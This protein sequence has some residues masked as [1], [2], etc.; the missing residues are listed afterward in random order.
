MFSERLLASYT[1]TASLQAFMLSQVAC[2]I[3]DGKFKIQHSGIIAVPGRIDPKWVAWLGSPPGWMWGPVNTGRVAL[4]APWVPVVPLQPLLGPL[5]VAGKMVPPPTSHKHSFSTTLQC[6]N[7]NL[8][9]SI[10]RS[11]YENQSLFRSI[12]P[13]TSR[14][15]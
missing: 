6:T 10:L 3:H 13:K 12:K 4:P 7:H 5:V 1:P 11:Q 8:L 2:I 9:L 15:K 14:I